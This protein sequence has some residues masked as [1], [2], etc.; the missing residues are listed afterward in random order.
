MSLSRQFLYG[1][2]PSA[3]PI[4]SYLAR[5]TSQNQS[6]VQGGSSGSTA[7]IVIPAVSN[8]F[9]DSRSGV[10]TFDLTN[11]SVASGGAAAACSL[12]MSASSVIASLKVYSGMNSASLLEDVVN[13]AEL[14]ATLTQLHSSEADFKYRMSVNEGTSESTINQG[15][16]LAAGST[17][18]F[19]IPLISLLGTLSEKAIPLHDGFTI[20]LNFSPGASALYSTTTTDT[21]SYQISGITYTYNVLELPGDM[22]G[23]LYRNGAIKIPCTKW[24][25]LTNTLQYGSTAYQVL[26]GLG[27]TSLKSL[28]FRFRFATQIANATGFDPYGRWVNPNLSNWYLTIQGVR[29]PNMSMDN[30]QFT[31]DRLLES[32]HALQ[33]ANFPTLIGKTSYSNKTKPVQSTRSAGTWC[34]GIDFDVLSSSQ[35]AMVSGVDVNGK[36]LQAHFNFDSASL[37]TTE[38]TNLQGV[39]FAEASAELTHVPNV[40]MQISY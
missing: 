16:A 36:I 6:Y 5:I 28:L 21:L 14:H 26:L 31:F 29:I 9:L 7:Q 37:L 2:L 3:A 20:F 15:V 19:S 40:G 27:L 33:A 8:S 10:I 35:E 39:F 38:T 4:K 13:Y 34:A 22:V 11:T 25:T 17:T 32:R 30:D 24:V 23:A 18:R 12:N 1:S